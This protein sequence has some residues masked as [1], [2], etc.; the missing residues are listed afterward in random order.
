M[1]KGSNKYKWILTGTLFITS[2]TVFL[3]TGC[4]DSESTPGSSGSGTEST[5]TS[6]PTGTL[7]SRAPID[8]DDITS[9]GVLSSLIPP[10]H[11][12]PT[13]HLYIYVLDTDATEDIT[14]TV[15]FTKSRIR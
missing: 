8:L 6:C 7:F 2:V 1:K 12:F 9:M 15:P 5:S 13:P 14:A 3:F 10:G 11:T 4:G